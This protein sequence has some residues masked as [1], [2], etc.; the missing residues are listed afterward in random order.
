MEIRSMLAARFRLVH[1]ACTCYRCQYM[2]LYTKCM[3]FMFRWEYIVLVLFVQL[4]GMGLIQYFWL[5]LSTWNIILSRLS[6]ETQCFSLDRFC[7]ICSF[8]FLMSTQYLKLVLGVELSTGNLDWKQGSS[9]GTHKSVELV[10]F[11][12]WQTSTK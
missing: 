3:I 10:I 8:S 5:W 9:T 6:F 11:Y 2:G 4:P 1:D 7:W 12:D